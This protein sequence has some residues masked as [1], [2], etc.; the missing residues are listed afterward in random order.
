LQPGLLKR[1]L[2]QILGR[3]SSQLLRLFEN[4]AHSLYSG[5]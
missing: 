5:A 1:P 2:E 4:R 3:S